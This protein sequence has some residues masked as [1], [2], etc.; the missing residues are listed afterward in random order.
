MNNK[1]E[2]IARIAVN[3]AMDMIRTH[4]TDG[5]ALAVAILSE[6]H[7]TRDLNVIAST[8]I[9]TYVI[10]EAKDVKSFKK[11]L[12]ETTILDSEF[13]EQMLLKSDEELDE[14]LEEL[15]K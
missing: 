13:R 3:A 4:N 8:L 11:I 14:F 10:S 7:N 9:A 2:E 6:T 15:R 5:L 12:S 1:V